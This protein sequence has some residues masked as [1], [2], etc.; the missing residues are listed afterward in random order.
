MEVE[1]KALFKVEVVEM[2]VFMIGVKDVEEKEA[3]D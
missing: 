2:A 1:R 3:V